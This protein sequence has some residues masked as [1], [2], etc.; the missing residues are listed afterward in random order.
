MTNLEKLLWGT[1]TH[2]HIFHSNN[3]TVELALVDQAK[4]APKV[5]FCQAMNVT[6][7]Q[8]LWEPSRL[9]GKFNNSIQQVSLVLFDTLG[10]KYQ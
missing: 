2:L 8:A 7:L 1:T 10:L 4:P 5:G 9:P 3:T 6:K